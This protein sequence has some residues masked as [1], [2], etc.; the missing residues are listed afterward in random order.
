MLEVLKINYFLPFYAIAWI[1]SIIKLPK[2]YDSFLKYLPIIIGYTLFTE[3][4]GVLIYNFDDFTF[5]SVSKYSNYNIILYNIYDLIFFPF[6][7]YIYW[8]SIKNNRI[9]K[10]IKFGAFIYFLS[11]LVNSFFFSPLLN[12]MWYAYTLGAVVLI[13]ST[14][15]YL[16][17]LRFESKIFPISTNLLFWLSVGLL[18]FHIVYLPMTIIKNVD[19]NLTIED[20]SYLRNIQFYFIIAMYICFIIG[21]LLM[22]RIRPQEK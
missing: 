19:S 22:R 6:F 4:L 1:L 14:I 12:E 21:F 18:I 8:H 20:Y 16:N 15:T 7:Y 11:M 5:F 10:I 3:L 2:Y 9:K 17:A 13:I